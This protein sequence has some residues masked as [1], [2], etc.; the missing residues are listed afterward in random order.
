MIGYSIRDE[1][2]RPMFGAGRK[3]GF[4]GALTAIKE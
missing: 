1:P 3:A 2:E 4:Y